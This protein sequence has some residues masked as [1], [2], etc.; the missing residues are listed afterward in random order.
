MPEGQFT[1][2]RGIYAYT[3][4]SGTVYLLQL[5]ET[6]GDIPGCGLT[7]A[8]N[9]TAGSPAPRRFK[10]RGVYWQGKLGQD[11]KRK[12]LVCGSNSVLYQADRSQKLTIDGVEGGTTGRIGEKLSYLALEEAPREGAL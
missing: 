6:L 5:D 12:F 4:E 8:N 11:I 2:K 3:S 10:A 1:G 7:K 9:S